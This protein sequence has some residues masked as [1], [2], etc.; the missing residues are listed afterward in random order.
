MKIVVKGFLVFLSFFSFSNLLAQGK[1]TVSV[2]N[3]KSNKG[4]CRIC[5]FDDAKAFNGEGKPVECVAATVKDKRA[6]AFFDKVP[7]GTY[8]ISV[9][10][11]A[12]SN[13][14]FD[15][16]FL[17]MPTEGYGASKNKLPF[18]A[19]PAFK[20]NQFTLQNGLHLQLSIRLR[21]L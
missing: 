2:S 14:K 20:D 19:A 7:A 13:N 6:T 15:V 5:I 10:H 18:A 9:F 16:N 4:V 8:A 21:N 3:F 17:G 12:N 1:V 11:D